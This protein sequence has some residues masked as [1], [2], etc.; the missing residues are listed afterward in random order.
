LQYHPAAK[1]LETFARPTGG[2]GGER[3]AIARNRIGAEESSASLLAAN[4]PC[5]SGENPILQEPAIG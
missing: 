5:F 1:S 4:P 3:R 2:C